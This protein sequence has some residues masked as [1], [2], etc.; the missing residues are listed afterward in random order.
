MTMFHPHTHLHSYAHSPVSAL[1][2]SLCPTRPRRTRT[3]LTHLW[4]SAGR[5][6]S[7]RASTNR[8]SGHS[9]ACRTETCRKKIIN[10]CESS[11]VVALGCECSYPKVLPVSA[12]S[13]NNFFGHIVGFE[14]PHHIMVFPPLNLHSQNDKVPF[15]GPVPTTSQNFWTKSQ[16]KL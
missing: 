2:R 7:C 3:A 16:N 1:C 10:C 15:V 6:P 11:T 5:S 14:C 12:K 9:A 4:R 8:R 13:S